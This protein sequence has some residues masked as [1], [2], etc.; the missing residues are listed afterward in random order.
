MGLT[1][2]LLSFQWT[3]HDAT[4]WGSCADSQRHPE[5]TSMPCD[6]DLCY[7]GSPSKIFWP[8]TLSVT[9][10]DRYHCEKRLIK[11]WKSSGRCLFDSIPKI[12]KDAF[13]FL[14]PNAH[15][16]TW[17]CSRTVL[18]SSKF[19]LKYRLVPMLKAQFI[20]NAVNSSCNILTRLLWSILT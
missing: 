6:D 9:I 14:S 11:W 20:G 3:G 7:V 17:T 16:W 13:L 4:I 1:H 12:S 5:M 10:K 15:S 19:G 18:M 8:I 2:W